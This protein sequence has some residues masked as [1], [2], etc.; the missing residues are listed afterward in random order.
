MRNGLSSKR[1]VTADAPKAAIIRGA[2]EPVGKYLVHNALAEPFRRIIV[3]VVYGYL[4]RIR[5]IAA[6]RAL[7]GPPAVIYGTV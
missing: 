5:R 4:I 3:L 2:V 1:P 7:T 6:E